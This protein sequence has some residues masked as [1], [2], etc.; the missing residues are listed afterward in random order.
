MFEQ[1]QLALQ[2]TAIEHLTSHRATVANFTRVLNIVYGTANSALTLENRKALV[3]L[4]LTT[5]TQTAAPAAGLMH[6]IK[7]PVRLLALAVSCFFDTNVRL[8]D[9]QPGFVTVDARVRGERGIG[10]GHILARSQNVL[11]LQA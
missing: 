3:E 6:D 8:A 7:R 11:D 10:M 5:A 2:T 9:C 4:V 1:A